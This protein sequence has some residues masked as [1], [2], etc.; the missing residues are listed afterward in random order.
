VGK[1][2]T[3]S[4]ARVFVSKPDEA[5]AEE[6]ELVDVPIL[7]GYSS[8]DGLGIGKPGTAHKSSSVGNEGEGYATATH[9]G[10]DGPTR[11][12]RNTDVVAPR[13]D[14]Y[15]SDDQQDAVSI[16][17]S[18]NGTNVPRRN[19]TTFDVAALIFNKMVSGVSWPAS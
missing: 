11:R 4:G 2:D 5:T 13:T 16:V 14:S 18:Q 12:H 19:L 10:W 1:N 7:H 3:S 6:H 17:W 15:D 8:V 9:V